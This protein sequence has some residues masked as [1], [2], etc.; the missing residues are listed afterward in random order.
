MTQ[1]EMLS[2][3]LRQNSYACGEI[4]GKRLYMVLTLSPS[5]LMVALE[6]DGCYVHDD[7]SKPVNRYK[8]V[9]AGFDVLTA[10]AVTTVLNALLEAWNEP[11]TAL[12]GHDGED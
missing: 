8:L 3:A 6:N 2:Q 4:G 12:L 9:G 5:S 1:V 11:D 10:P 7:F